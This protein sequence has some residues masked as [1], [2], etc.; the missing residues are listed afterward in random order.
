MR[1]RSSSSASKQLRRRRRRRVAFVQPRLHQVRELAQPHRAR[2]PRAAL[3]RVQRPPQLAPSS[4][5]RRARA[6]CAQ[7]LAG[8]REE[9]GR[10]LEEDRQHV[11]VDLVADV[12]QR[13]VRATS[14]RSRARREARAPRAPVRGTQARAAP[15]RLPASL[16]G[17]RGT[18]TGPRAR[19]S[20]CSS[21]A[22]SSSACDSAST[23]VGTRRRLLA[24]SLELALDLGCFRGV[25]RGEGG[26][27]AH[28]RDERAQPFDGAGEH[29][30]R[31]A[32]QRRFA[33]LRARAA[34]ARA[35][36]QSRR[37]AGSR[38][39]DGC[40]TACGSRAP[41]PA[42]GVCVRIEL[43]HLELARRASRGAGRPRRSGCRTGRPT[44]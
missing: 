1:S 33:L 36:S 43:Q 17:R 19:A 29:R 37:S 15:P 44:A 20:S 27:V 32:G 22:A 35:T 18:A 38:R 25:G 8:L 28:A 13:I 40:R 4:S 11:L 10:F 24:Q 7:L 2:H 39:C 21:R 5:G 34:P 42:D 6:P 3:E 14:G 12:G 41:S 9:L 31:G 23:S 26:A 16:G 30:Q